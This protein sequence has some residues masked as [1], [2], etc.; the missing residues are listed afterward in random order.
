MDSSISTV[1]PSPPIF[2]SDGGLESIS[3]TTFAFDPDFLFMIKTMI[4]GQGF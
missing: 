1:L 2:F 3:E 4:I